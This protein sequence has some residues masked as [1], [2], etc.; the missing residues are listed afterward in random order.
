MVA[1]LSENISSW[2]SDWLQPSTRR[3]TLSSALFCPL[4]S[5][6]VL[7]LHIANTSC[8]TDAYKPMPLYDNSP[9]IEPCH[10][11]TSCSYL[12]RSMGIPFF[13]FFFFLSLYLLWLTSISFPLSSLSRKDKNWWPG[14]YKIKCLWVMFEHLQWGCDS[15]MLQPWV[16][17]GWRV[18][19][20]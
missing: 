3:A 13:F 4:Y 12:I 16:L 2:V 1:F 15:A 18:Q 20:W 14:K 9:V 6:S 19:G 11:I 7:T 17:S 10:C 5:P 8:N